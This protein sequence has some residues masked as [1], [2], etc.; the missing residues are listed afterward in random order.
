MDYIQ[1][2][3]LLRNVP[4]G[5]TER[6]VALLEDIPDN[7]TIHLVADEW[8]GTRFGERKS[9]VGHSARIGKCTVNGK[10]YQIW[11]VWEVASGPA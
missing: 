4:G 11:A 10:V 3:N 1:A 7:A 8:T 2:C 9:R 6:R 5:A